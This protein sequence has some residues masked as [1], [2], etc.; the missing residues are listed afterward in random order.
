MHS[1]MRLEPQHTVGA[2]LYRCWGHWT[3]EFGSRM[4]FRDRSKCCSNLSILPSTPTWDH[5]NSQIFKNVKLRL[6]V[7]VAG[8]ACCTADVFVC[9]SCFCDAPV[10]PPSL[11]TL[12]CWIILHKYFIAKSTL[13]S[14]QTCQAWGRITCETSMGSIRILGQ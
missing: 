10:Y 12:S 6:N 7:A 3:L 8:A 5:L 4:I 11:K 13:K 1:S 9:T 2:W 14:W